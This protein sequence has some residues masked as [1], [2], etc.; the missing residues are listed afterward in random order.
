[1]KIDLRKI[2]AAHLATLA[3]ARTGER[4][5]QDLALFFGVPVAV[6]VGCLALKVEMSATAAAGLLTVTGLLGAFLFGV[7]LQVT[8]R[9]MSWAD[10]DP[11]RGPETSRH[12]IFL[13]QIAANAGYASIVASLASVVFIVA[14]VTTKLP[15]TIAASVGLAVGIHAL[16]T[17]LMVIV[18]IH[19][20]TENRLRRARTG[21]GTGSVSRIDERRLG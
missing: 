18:R 3:D 17:L 8:D 14:S 10:S 9:A 16:L 7:M 2:F 21:T 4:R 13:G 12:A 11:H 20:L 6:L 15:N 5:W 19:A 1:M